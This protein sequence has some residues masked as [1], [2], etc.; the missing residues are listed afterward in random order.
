VQTYP[1]EPRGGNLLLLVGMFLRCHSRK[2]NGK[3]HRYWSVVESRRL[4][5][6]QSAQRQL[7][8]LGEINDS[9]EAAWRK[10]I[11]VFD[12]DKQQAGQATLFPADRPIPPHEVNGLSLVMSDIRL[13]RPR[14][15]G[16]CWLGCQL[17]RELELDRFWQE[18][19]HD[20]RGG[21]PWE[22]VLQLLA[23]NRLCQPASEWAV[24]RQWFLDS[25]MDQ[26][27]DCNFA[28]AEKDRLYRCLD[29]VLAHKDALC[30]HLVDR[31]KTLFDA[32]FDIL[33]YDLT[34]TY[35]EGQSQQIPKAKHGYSRD[36]RSDCRQ[37]VIALVVTTDGLPLAYEVLAGNRSDKTTLT[38]FLQKIQSMY[39]QA[40]RV[41][42]MD[43]GIPTEATLQQMRED[44]VAYLVGTPKALLDKLEK[45]LTDQPWEQ[46]HEG[47]KVKLLEQDGELYIQAASDARRKKENAMR[48]RRLK[49]LVHGLNRL[50]RRV[51]RMKIKRDYLLERIAVLRKE[52]G[53][54]STF[55]QITKPA[56]GE[57]VNRTTFTAKLDKAA[58][59]K[60]IERDGCYLLR[61]SVPWEQWPAEMEKQAPVLWKWYMQLVRVEEAFKTLKG[62]LNLRPI[63]HQLQSRVEAHILV[64]FLG[65]CLSSSLRMKLSAAAPGLTPRA[66]L[67]SLSAIQRLEVQVPTSDGRVLVMP[68]YT[69]PEAQQNMIL[70]L[71]KLTLPPQPPPRIRDG[72]P[73]L[74]ELSRANI[75]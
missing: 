13:L 39:G 43:R 29:R 49:K 6:G 59:K 11:E 74:P 57:E 28:V 21:V 12:E 26:L 72:K 69:E 54:V 3:L 2:K 20:Q 75:L 30:R 65:Y 14:R 9:Q 23:I 58:W 32:R 24:H 33:L 17:W 8:Y 18:Q 25:A 38:L 7:L 71:L 34:S 62:D 10:S 61:A 52:A 66:A 35:F 44:Q 45:Q 73:E 51:G 5:N 70:D 1:L 36:G 16:D 63:H 56:A 22:K 27:L 48:R 46:V 47:M 53:R 50:K 41:W 40:R 4:D 37:V 60:A 64:A 68:R 42:I 19:L 31:W 15:F 55:V 67:A